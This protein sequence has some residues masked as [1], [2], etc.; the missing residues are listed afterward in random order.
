MYE[1]SRRTQNNN[2]ENYCSPHFNECNDACRYDVLVYVW[3]G[4][5]FLFSML[6]V[7]VSE[8][9]GIFFHRFNGNLK[10]CDLDRESRSSDVGIW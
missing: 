10:S 1:Q 6:S 8:L 3:K 7:N 5:C 4:T 9:V 2:I